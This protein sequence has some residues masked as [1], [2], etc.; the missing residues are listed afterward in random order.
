M[1]YTTDVRGRLG[2]RDED[3]DCSSVSVCHGRYGIGCSVWHQVDRFSLHQLARHTPPP[4]TA[5]GP[6]EGVG[7]LAWGIAEPSLP[8]FQQ[9]CGV[10]CFFFAEDGEQG[11]RWD[12]ELW[13]HREHGR[14][15]RREA[16]SSRVQCRQHQVCSIGFPAPV[17]K[18]PAFAHMA[19]QG[20]FRWPPAFYS[21]CLR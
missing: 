13:R 21:A 12:R 20:Q 14:P 1:A 4:H 5:H 6:R 19:A 8:C 2:R 9:R 7:R 10:L 17:A 16:P 3:P 18:C 15:S 11:L